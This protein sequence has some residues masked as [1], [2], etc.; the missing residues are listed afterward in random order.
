MFLGCYTLFE[1]R[2]AP[3]YACCKCGASVKDN[4]LY[5]VQTINKH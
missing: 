3:K 1:A 5:C 4:I 2:I